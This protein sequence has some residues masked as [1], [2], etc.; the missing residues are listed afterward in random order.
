MG[1]S[2][3]KKASEFRILVV[4]DEENVCTM[5]KETLKDKY[6]VDTCYNVNDALYNIESTDYD[7]VI[8]DLKLEDA[9][10]I[11]VLKYA[12]KKDKFTEVIII[13]GYGSIETA[14]E[15]INLGVI[16]YLN[17]PLKINDLYI[18]VERAVASRYFHL[19]SIRLL[20][21]PDSK[22]ILDVR[23]HILD[24][25]S[26]Y[27][28]T[29]KLMFSLNVEGVMR[30]ILEEVNEKLET[31]CT[32]I[33]VNYLE[34]KEM[35]AMPRIGKMNA[36]DVISSILSVWDDSFSIFTRE[37]V[38][39]EKISLHMYQGKQ[40]TSEKKI[41][42][43]SFGSFIGV[44]MNILGERMG[45]IALFREEKEPIPQERSQF[46]YVF[47]SLISSAVQHCYMDL[48]AKEQAKTDSLTGVA[49]HRMFHE[50]FEREL[51]LLKRHKRKFSLIMLDIDDFKKI[52]DTHGHL[53]GDA[54]LVDLTK[55]ILKI[56]RI[57]DVLARYGGEE[58]TV[59][60]PDT[61]L[62]GAEIL[63]SRICKEISDTPFM[64]SD[65]EI[66]YTVSIGL[67]ACD[68]DSP[69]DKDAIIHLA[70]EALYSAKR[71]GKNRLVVSR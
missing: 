7:L 23:E 10:G 3:V 61:D 12:K 36:K 53:V 54:I 18:Q 27:Y 17:K 5:L 59:I 51:S 68:N 30:I 50:I 56:T 37:D 16:S 62:P 31:S 45:F 13:T 29:S 43:K 52:N 47:T 40:Q 28:F 22:D 49:N 4:D 48:L 34:F 8:T 67:V 32:I 38:E 60:L 66:N 20:N 19:K 69:S 15:A 55:R 65:S 2:K 46:L 14:S 64:Y 26:L 33:G 35:F 63:A 25:T 71:S 24:I 11:D 70:D 44:P 41:D 57:E 9:S 6:Q 39:N 21:Q 1:T 58:F 42:N